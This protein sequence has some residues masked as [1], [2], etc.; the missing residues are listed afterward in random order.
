MEDEAEVEIEF[1][2]PEPAWTF[3]E[4]LAGDGPPRR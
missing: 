1:L 2:G 3:A 4:F